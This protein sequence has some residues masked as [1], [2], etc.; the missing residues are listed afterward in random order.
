MRLVNIG[1]LIDGTDGHVARD[2]AIIVQDGRIRWIGPQE[3]M[4]APPAAEAGSV[5]DVRGRT[6]LPGF[7]DV[8]VHLQSPTAGSD[9]WN[10]DDAG[11]YSAPL[12]VTVLRMAR[13]AQLALAAGLT[14]IRD[15]GSRDG[16]ARQVRDSID[17]GLIV[18]PRILAAGR[19]ITTTAGHGYLMGH[20]ADSVTEIRKAVRTEVKAGSDFVKVM[21]TG[22][23]ST[24]GTNALA[25][26]YSATELC[27]AVQDAHRLGKKVAA[28]VYG[29]EGIRNCVEAGVDSLEHY[30]WLTER[31]TTYG[32]GYDEGIVAEMAAKGLSVVT[33]L[34]LGERQKRRRARRRGEA[35]YAHYLRERSAHC[36]S[37]VRTLDA[38]VRLCVGTDAGAGP[39]ARI[40][41]LTLNA[42]DFVEFLGLSPIEAIAT[43]TVNPAEMMGLADRIGSLEVGKEADLVVVDGDPL[44]NLRCL[45]KA[46]MV[47]RAGKLVARDGQV[48]ATRQL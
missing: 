34:G 8:H 1:L 17:R 6:V 19:V 48:I 40:H 12:G 43:M 9:P 42:E 22:G 16:L 37:I 3:Q 10:A 41:A 47:V 14:T 31:D 25:P 46:R 4:P 23:F 15:C 13:N 38:G 5:L 29:A 36:E 21:A 20:E 35:A 26:Q 24:P 7:I 30:F 33:A 32:T 28:H 44:A 27:A 2:Q 11:M 45:R 18:G 39:L